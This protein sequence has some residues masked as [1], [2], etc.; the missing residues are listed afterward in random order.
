MPSECE[1]MKK[2]IWRVPGLNRPFADYEPA[3]NSLPSTR[4]LK[5]TQKDTYQI[6]TDALRLLPHVRHYTNVTHLFTKSIG[7]DFSINV[8]RISNPQS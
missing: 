6:R 3:K 8:E 4:D 5:R 2:M 1:H 7:S